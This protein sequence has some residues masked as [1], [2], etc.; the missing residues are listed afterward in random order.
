M[1]PS[2]RELRAGEVESNAH[3][4]GEDAHDFS[5]RDA[6]GNVAANEALG[7]G[8]GVT[9]RLHARRRYTLSTAHSPATRATARARK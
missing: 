2:Y 1:T 5:V 6:G 3:N 8:D 9:V 4:L 7:P